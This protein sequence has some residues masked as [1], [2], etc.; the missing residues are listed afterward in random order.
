MNHVYLKLGELLLAHQA[1][2]EAQL[3]AALELQANSGRRLGEIL[4]EHAFVKEE[5][6]AQCLAQQY[7]CELVEPATLKPEADALAIMDP[8]EAL[9]KRVLPVRFDDHGLF[10]VIAD[11]LNLPVTDDLVH[12]VKRPI[13][14]AVAPESALLSAIRAHFGLTNPEDSAEFGTF[15]PKRYQAP[16]Y[17]GRTGEI[18]WGDVV[19]TVLKRKVSLFRAPASGAEGN[20][21]WDL[22][23]DGAVRYDSSFVP[24]YDSTVHKGFRWTSFELIR[25]ETLGSVIR[26][27]GPQPPLQAAE[28][29]AEIA[30]AAYEAGSAYHRRSWIS[31][32]NI[33]VD[34]GRA[35]IAPAMPVPDA[36]AETYDELEALGSLLLHCLSGRFNSRGLDSFGLSSQVPIG[37]IRILERCFRRPGTEAFESTKE[38]AHAL[39]S[40]RW[41]PGSISGQAKTLDREELLATM[42]VV[43]PKRPSLWER[44]V[45]R[46]A[47]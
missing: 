27:C 6:I 34:G 2:T 43:T 7:G 5:T 46:R 22:V 14:F 38:L 33:W 42:S 4:V 16:E 47:A 19:D 13:H 15:V 23:R 9:G 40:F 25:G 37:M 26:K 35:T 18:I 11:P 12:R 29:I 36:Y 17:R 30:R 8:I 20:E 10:C 21:H 45:G 3:E 31:P 32:E 1:I 44:F 39:Q 24:V 28:I 41:A